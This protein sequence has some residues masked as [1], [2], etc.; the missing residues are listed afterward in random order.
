MKNNTALILVALGLGG[1]VWWATS[2]KPAS[3]DTTTPPPQTDDWRANVINDST[4]TYWCIA[5][6]TPD[7]SGNL[8]IQTVNGVRAQ[9]YTYQGMVFLAWLTEWHIGVYIHD[10]TGNQNDSAVMVADLPAFVDGGWVPS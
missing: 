8:G 4:G 2:K 3:A 5:G 6:R 9:T 1:L 7:A 10:S